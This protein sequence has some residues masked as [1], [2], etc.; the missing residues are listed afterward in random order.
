MK[1]YFLGFKVI[2]SL[3]GGAMNFV[4]YLLLKRKNIQFYKIYKRKYLLILFNIF[5]I[6]IIF[7][8]GLYA[9]LNNLLSSIGL[10][11]SAIAFIYYFY[12]MLKVKS[13]NEKLSLDLINRYKK[14]QNLLISEFQYI[15]NFIINN[16]NSELNKNDYS[17]RSVA[18]QVRKIF[19]AHYD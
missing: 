2:P 8:L 3:W 9:K 16:C 4:I 17:V 14:N 11:I 12:V 5:L 10:L 6:H 1:K 19:F 13:E 15:N 7:L 18:K